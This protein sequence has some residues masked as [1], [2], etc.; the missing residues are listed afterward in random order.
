VEGNQ[1]VPAILDNDELVLVKGTALF[2][3]LRDELLASVLK[4]SSVQEFSSGEILFVQGDEVSASYI[5]LEGWLKLYR[6]NQ[7][8]GEAVVNVFTRGQS[9]A[10]AAVFAMEAYPVTAEAVTDARLI[11]IPQNQLLRHVKEDPEFACSMLA[12]TSIHLQ[13]LVRQIEQLKTN[14]A[15]QRVARFLA[16]LCP[17]SEGSCTI[18]LPYDKTLIAGRLGM[19]PESLSR[20][21]AQLRNVGVKVEQSA[22]AIA[23]VEKLHGYATEDRRELR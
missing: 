15:T 4:V 1:G 8:G 20:A 12:S 7:Y 19:K 21:F 11:R 3:G 23:D 13:V 9:F 10:E 22:A 2:G 16:S 18:G 14:T 17:V 5:V 6:L